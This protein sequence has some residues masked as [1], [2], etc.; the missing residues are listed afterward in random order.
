MIWFWLIVILTVFGAAGSIEGYFDDRRDLRSGRPSFDTLFSLT[1]IIDR[2]FFIDLFGEPD[3]DDRFDVPP[4][5]ASQIPTT[6]WT[7]VDHPLLDLLCIVIAIAAPFV[8]LLE[9]NVGL[10]LLVVSAGSQLSGY[11]YAILMVLRS[12]KLEQ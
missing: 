6:W 11:C 5:R 3:E 8:F 2:E 9:K 12:E 4:A 10:A 1:G 7:I